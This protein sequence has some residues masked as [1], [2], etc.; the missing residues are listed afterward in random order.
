MAIYKR[1]KRYWLSYYDRST[2]TT[3]RV[4]LVPGGET[5]ATKSRAVAESLAKEIRTPPP[6]GDS[7]LAP[8]LKAYHPHA[9]LDM[10][11][12]TAARWIGVVERFAAR[13]EIANPKQITR[14]TIRAHL[15]DLKADGLS[16]ATLACH[17]TAISSFC[18]YLVLRGL[19]E[20]NPALGIRLKK[21]SRPAP[22]V[23]T[24]DAVEAIVLK[25]EDTPIALPVVIAADCGLRVGELRA[26]CWA[27]VNFR[28]NCI[29]VG[30]DDPSVTKGGYTRVVP[31]S[32][33]VRAGLKALR[34]GK[35]QDR[36]FWDASR[37]SWQK[38]MRDLTADI[39]GFAARKGMRVGR[40]WHA[41]RAYAAL[42]RARAGM[43]IYQIMQELGWRN[44]SNLRSYIAIAEAAKGR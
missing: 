37:W 22:V 17:K 16:P 1:G 36:L 12:E 33:R 3:K 31:M 40:Q 32:E 5:M 24:D 6:V 43:N 26:T 42:Q 34:R 20:D 35:P 15:A 2:S 39:P 13:Q 10:K 25:A 4:P 27:W 19:L 21:R 29:I 28:D 8:L 44:E 41:L 7:S 30:A 23:L 18:E 38:L 9:L 11:P 14:Q